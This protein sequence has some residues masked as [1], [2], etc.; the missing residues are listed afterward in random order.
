MSSRAKSR[1]LVV[2]LEVKATGF[3]ARPWQLRGLRYGF[4]CA[5]LRSE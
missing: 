4:D 5:A 3:K 2:K 1:D